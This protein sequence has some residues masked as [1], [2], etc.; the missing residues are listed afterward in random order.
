MMRFRFAYVAAWL[1]LALLAPTLASAAA[2]PRAG[3]ESIHRLGPDAH[4]L[5]F[6]GE[7]TS[8]NWTIYVTQSQAQTRARI[9]LAYSNAISV[10]PEVSTLAISV[11]DIAVAQTP[12]AAASDPGSVDVELPRGLLAAGYNNVR[13]SVTQRHRVDCSLEATY[14]LWTQLDP[15]TSGLT[16]PGLA[17]PAIATLDDLAA[18]SPDMTG[19]TPIRAVIAD[20]ADPETI[21][22]ALRAVQAVVIR[23][24]I[25]RPAVE[26]VDAIDERP[27]LWV[28]AGTRDDVRAGRLE[29]FAPESDEPVVLGGEVLGRVVV[30]AVGADAKQAQ[31]TIDKILPARRFETRAATPSAARGLANLNGL[32]VGGD[33]R[34][35]LREL[36]VQTEEFNGRIFR[37]GFDVLLPP[38][39]Y[40]AD[41]DKLTLS[42][43]AGYSKGLLPTSQVLVR[44]NEREA[45]SL[46]LRNPKGDLFQDMPISISLAALRPGVNRVTIEAQTPAEEDAACDVR[47]L[48]DAKKRFVLFDRSQL[49]MPSIARIARMP[50]LAITLTSAYPYQGADGARVYLAKHNRAT[51]GAAATFLARA[52]YISRRPASPRVTFKREDIANG[53]ALMFGALDDFTPATFDAFRVDYRALKEAW[54]RPEPNIAEVANPAAQA[55]ADSSNGP[56]LFDQWAEGVK[57]EPE[58]FGARASAR[59]LYDRYINV[60]RGDFAL[61][62]DPASKIETP[63]KTSIL[64][65]QAHAPSSG[66]YTWTIVVGASEQALLRDMRSLVAPSNWNQMEGRAAAFSPRSGAKTISWSGD[67]YFVQT[68]TFTPSNL[69]LVAAGWLSSNIDYYAIAVALMALVLGLVTTMAVRAHGAKQ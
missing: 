32:P 6:E 17:D 57:A 1:G 3:G 45:G 2:P 9:H 65:A 12:I 27:G 4:L 52:A 67:A 48:M 22:L 53:S 18:L 50:N 30:S 62:R 60:H 29:A 41:Y 20:G 25:A 24:G 36:G 40:P 15:A 51:V 23:A 8:K 49:I 11:N 47:N 5:R 43:S 46:P 26:I 66:P 38:D 42:I 10:M 54:A 64:V 39:F 19:A 14:E 68:Q 7:N 59:A 21:N 56:N 55:V 61:L 63:E 33:M 35:S 28:L 13:I 37:S 16:F 44:V 69:R 31:Q 34:V 58:H